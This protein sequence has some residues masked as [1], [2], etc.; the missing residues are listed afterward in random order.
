[1]IRGAAFILFG[2]VAI[3]S[4]ASAGDPPPMLIEPTKAH[5]C[6]PPSPPLI[7]PRAGE[8]MFPTRRKESTA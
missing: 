4:L 5:L 8:P 7:G 1:M 3:L 6:L 2:V